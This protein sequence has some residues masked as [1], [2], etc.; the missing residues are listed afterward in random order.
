MVEVVAS[1]GR[2]TE[3][4][5]RLFDAVLDRFLV[6]NAPLTP[7][8]WVRAPARWL[9]STRSKALHPLR[10]LLD[11]V[12]HS[13]RILNT[14]TGRWMLYE[15]SDPEQRAALLRMIFDHLKKADRL[16]PSALQTTWETLEKE[17]RERF[18]VG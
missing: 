3:E 15:T 5:R 10:V 17:S 12:K 14:V 11:R 2:S 7:L 8:K 4:C 13:E 6:P 1:A 16:Q 9:S 18:G